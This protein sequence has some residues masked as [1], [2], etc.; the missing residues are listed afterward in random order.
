[1][2]NELET[3]HGKNLY[4]VREKRE[5]QPAE[6]PDTEQLR[7]E[8]DTERLRKEIEPWLTALSQSEHLSLLIGSGFSLAACQ[9][10]KAQENNGMPEIEFS[11]FKD[12]IQTAS[13]QSAQRS[14][15]GNANIE[16]QIRTAN[17]LIKGLE[18][19]CT[20]RNN[21][22]EGLIQKI[23][24]LK[25]ELKAG[26]I[27]FA[28]QILLSERA[29]VCSNLKEETKEVSE[30]L[31]NFLISFASRSATRE[32]LNI[33]TTNYDRIIEYSAEMAG[34]RLIDRFL[35]TINPV[36]R[37]SRLDVD[38]HYNPPGIRG[39]P[40]YL[41]G[42]ARFA[43][44]H[45]SLDWIMQ[46]DVVK[47]IAL[48]YGADSIKKYSNTDSTLM[49]YPNAAK[50]RETS[51]YPYVELFRDLAAAVCRPNSTLVLYGYSL[52]DQHINLVIEDMLTIPS[53]HL[54]IIS[55]SDEG[56]RIKRFYDRVK[57]PAQISLLIGNHFG[58]LKMLVDHYLPKPSI[59][60]TT[61]KMAD[62]LKA[63][64]IVEPERPDVS[65][66]PADSEP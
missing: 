47:R 40:R 54:V 33:F 2:N 28:N 12:K 55:W 43:K 14:M 65:N 21:E 60:R 53:T 8:I 49:I 30:Y 31:M 44:L 57:R 61:I 17:E 3:W 58:D 13:E 9:I 37:S 46:G 26:L 36:F 10:V 34:I 32:R 51:E 66:N 59:D 19:Y 42:V 23:S 63:R 62:L 7:K 48:P 11:V 24:Q 50:D 4:K 41:E 29:I 25:N 52:G 38:M 35:G 5:P 45:G 18:I 6:K 39:E 15:R 56:N 27:K 16:D 22:G 64:G 1:M 20:N